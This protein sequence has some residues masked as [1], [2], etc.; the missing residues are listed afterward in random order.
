MASDNK[1]EWRSELRATLS[2]AW[3]LI[4]ANLTTQIIQATDAVL[5]GR[6]GAEALASVALALGLTFAITLFAL[7]L[8]TASAPM[9]AT[10]LG[11]RFNAVRDVRRTFRV[12]MW[13]ALLMSLP[14]MALLA[15]AEP[16]IVALGQE[17]RLAA[18]AGEFLRGY[19]WALPPWMAFQVM[20]NFLSVMERPGWV[21]TISTAG[22]LVNLGAGYALIFG[23]LGLPALGLFGGGLA[24]AITW[25]AM[26]LALAAVLVTDRQ[27]RR[28]HL[29]GRFWR[30][31]AKRFAGLFK[32]GLPI[33]LT[34]GFEGA[35]F[36]AAAYLMGLFG[37]ASVAGHQIALQIAATTFMVPMGLAQAATVRV[38]LAL[39]RGDGDGITRAGW[40]AFALG[41]GFMALMA[42]LMWAAPRPL[43]A[44]F[45][46]DTPANAAAIALGTSFL[47]IAAAFQLVDGAQVVAAG[48]LRGLH[49][50]RV[51]M[52][53]A[54]VG[55]WV[56]GLGVG[57]WLAF[58]RGW[59]GAGIWTGLAVGLAFVAALMIRRWA[60]RDRLGLV[61]PLRT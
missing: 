23:K 24:S 46:D 1:G 30:G 45:L 12:A 8:L 60:R 15:S 29:F 57:V 33:G 50:T 56:V 61:A 44:L 19:L 5:I 38:G 7:G 16:L 54:L 6:L 18:G 17:P 35:V 55:Y 41:V 4:L 2:L 43:I 36:S 21:L 22:I 10:A 31:D 49:D 20:R 32:L 28:F 26:A 39:G 51:P 47:L 14:I 13:A 53:Y 52:I 42:V 58:G 25:T 27:F 34:M 40:T 9:M 59:Q 3:P 11:A 37:A 48:M